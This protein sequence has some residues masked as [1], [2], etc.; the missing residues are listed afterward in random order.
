MTAAQQDEVQMALPS[1]PKYLPLVRAVV[2]H[3]AVAAGFDEED[4]HRI[5]L[6]VTEG[7]TNV[8]RH[9]YHGNTDRK[10][11]LV[12]RSPPG[13]FHLEISDYGNFVDPAE[14]ESRPLDDVRP[15]GLGVHLM[16]ATM[17]EVAYRQN[18]HG[19]T[20]LTLVKHSSSERESS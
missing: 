19:G 13:L 11:D 17:D 8:I 9:S 4:C 15:G 2:E 3:G 6:A 12:L 1:H 18:H 16:K 7:V 20:T 5:V 10:I 14:I